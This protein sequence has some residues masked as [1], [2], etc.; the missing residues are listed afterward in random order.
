MSE[1][2]D[3]INVEEE[4]PQ[5]TINVENEAQDTSLNENVTQMEQNHNPGNQDS[6]QATPVDSAGTTD[7][8]DAILDKVNSYLHSANDVIDKAGQV[9]SEYANPFVDFTAKMAI[10]FKEFFNLT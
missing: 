3:S 1:N 5:I 6:L 2:K 9:T 7:Y 4:A 8:K 10:K